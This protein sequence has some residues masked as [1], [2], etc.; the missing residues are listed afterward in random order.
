[1]LDTNPSTQRILIFGESIFE[2]GIAQLL[3][4]GVGLQVAS[5]R[6]TNELAFLT[7]IT[8]NQPDVVL[9]NESVPL[10]LVYVFK[11]LF[12]RPDLANLRIIV[13]RLDNNVIDVYVVPEQVVARNGYERQQYNVT[14]PAELVAVVRG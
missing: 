13:T 5:T 1:M 7:E 2:E 10:N 12:A 11:L 6:F 9:L 8:Q 3:A 14:K 4:S